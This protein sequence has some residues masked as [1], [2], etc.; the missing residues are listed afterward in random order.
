[1]YT[2]ATLKFL[3]LNT[4]AQQREAVVQWRS[5][6][7]YQLRYKWYFLPLVADKL[8]VENR[9]KNLIGIAKYNL[10]LN[11]CKMAFHTIN[12]RS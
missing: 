6:S 3:K 8:S 12:Q 10:K 4:Q 1:V 5:L 2:E 11:F 7:P 9:T